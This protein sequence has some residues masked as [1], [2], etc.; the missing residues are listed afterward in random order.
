MHT[1]P[2]LPAANPA[3]RVSPML[4]LAEISKASVERSKSLVKNNTATHHRTTRVV[5]CDIDIMLARSNMSAEEDRMS[6]VMTVFKLLYRRKLAQ[7]S[8]ASFRTVD[9]DPPKVSLGPTKNQGKNK[10]PT[11]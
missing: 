2:T 7:P 5:D 6:S 8:V 4:V 11:P 1:H 3:P 9:A 10:T